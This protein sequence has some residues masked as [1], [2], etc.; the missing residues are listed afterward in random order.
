MSKRDVF[1]KWQPQ[2]AK[3]GIATFPVK[4]VERDGKIEKVPAVRNYMKLGLR[5]STELTRR[6]AEEPGIGIACG[7]HSGLAVADVDTKDENVV[8]DVLG[9]YGPS[10]LISRTPSGGHHVYYR[11][12]GR[13]GR[14]VRDR[15]WRDRGAPVDVLGNGMVVAPPSR[16]PNGIYKFVQGSLDDLKHLPTMR[17]HAEGEPPSEE[18]KIRT[19]RPADE[20]LAQSRLRGMREHDGRNT[21]LF[22]VIGPFARAIHQASGTVDQLLEIARRH[23]AQCE[24]PMAEREMERIVENVWGMTLQGRN[25]IGQADMFFLMAEHLTIDPDAFKLLAFLRLHQGPHAHFM[26]A[27]R[28][29]RRPEFDCAPRRI[30][31]ARHKLIERGDIV[32]VRQAGRGHPALFR[33]GRY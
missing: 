12:N 14:R 6:F 31:R 16:S 5:A 4:F 17:A 15:Y 13:Q 29:S 26:V 24:E 30:A 18:S 9:F 19:L 20:N 32:P 27:N 8:A 2:Y 22:T 3:R 25:F 23:N 7:Y 1:D 33:W 28:L 21:A 11:H 10:P